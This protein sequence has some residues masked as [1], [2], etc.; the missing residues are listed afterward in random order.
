M[1]GGAASLE[2]G[3]FDDDAMSMSTKA[4]LEASGERRVPATDL[5]DELVRLQ[6]PP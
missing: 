3:P 1:V 4:A 6:R 2:P 5:G